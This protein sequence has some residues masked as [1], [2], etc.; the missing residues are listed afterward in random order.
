MRILAIG[1]IHG[2]SNAFDTL[3][4]MV[5][6]GEGDRIITLG[7][8]VDRGPDSKGV[9]DRLIELHKGGQLVALRGNH[10][11]MMLEARSHPNALNGWKMSGGHETLLSYNSS[12]KKPRLEDVPA[13]H[14]EF[15]EQT[16]VDCWEEETHFFV[17]ANADPDRPLSEQSDHDRFWAKFYNARPHHSGKVMVCGHTSQKSGQPLNYGYAVCIDTRVYSNKGWLTCLDVTT[18]RM[19]Q[20]NQ[21]GEK[22]TAWIDEFEIEPYRFKSAFF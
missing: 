6:P 4:K 12:S 15:L 3:I 13:E 18:G 9:I 2:C 1:D 14:W 17:H 8:Y 10:E 7:D 20:A 16:C 21:K 22:R 5:N 11:I 19:W